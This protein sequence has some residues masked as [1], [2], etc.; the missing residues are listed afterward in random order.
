LTLGSHESS[1]VV[2]V[3]GTRSKAPSLGTKQSMKSI[4]TLRR[5]ILS[6]SRCIAAFARGVVF[7]VFSAA[8]IGIPPDV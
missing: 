7:A 2:A 3:V 4:H 1:S 8:A 6:F 5:S